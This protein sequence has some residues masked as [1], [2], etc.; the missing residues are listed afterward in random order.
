[1]QFGDQPQDVGE[2]V[3]A[4]RWKHRSKKN[5]TCGSPASGS[6]TRPHAFVHVMA[7]ASGSLIQRNLP[8]RAPQ[9]I[10]E[11]S[12]RPRRRKPGRVEG[13]NRVKDGDH[14][15]EK[16]R[17]GKGRNLPRLVSQ[18]LF[19]DFGDVG[20]PVEIARAGTWHVAARLCRSFLDLSDEGGRHF[21]FAA[22]RR[23]NAVREAFRNEGRHLR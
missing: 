11:E 19:E 5:R 2:E 16:V 3:S 13:Y 23:D 15:D 21:A 22:R 12:C 20:H 10:D 7:E 8:L 4:A 6:R 14:A 1:M 18:P 17:Y 9:R